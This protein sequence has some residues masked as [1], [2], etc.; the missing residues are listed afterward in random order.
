MT[1]SNNRPLDAATDLRKGCELTW[2]HDV[3][4]DAGVVS[5]YANRDP[6][7]TEAELVAAA[8]AYV[9]RVSQDEPP[10]YD[11]ADYIDVLAENA[12]D[13]IVAE[14]ASPATMKRVKDA[15]VASTDAA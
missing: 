14:S 6:L 9:K 13:R 1:N 11:L 8:A 2:S 4:T 7:H 3:I 5:K 15:I 12:A 10:Q